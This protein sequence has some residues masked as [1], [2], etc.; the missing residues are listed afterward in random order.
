MKVIRVL[1][2]EL[3]G[4]DLFTAAVID[5]G[6][7]Y[8][9]I[10]QGHREERHYKKEIFLVVR[11]LGADNKTVKPRTPTQSTD[12]IHRSFYLIVY[13][14]I[15]SLFS[16]FVFLSL[17]APTLYL[18]FLFSVPVLYHILAKLHKETWNLIEFC[19]TKQL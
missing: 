10:L 17:N 11:W 5:S 13:A 4:Y 8:L 19:K 6:I 18:C 1:V 14:K 12:N 3:P 15:S 9:T 2:L 7:C 16:H